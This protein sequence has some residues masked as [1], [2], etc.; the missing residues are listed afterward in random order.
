[1]FGE[2]EIK[3]IIQKEVVDNINL[4]NLLYREVQ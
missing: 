3:F 4:I 2:M 1:M